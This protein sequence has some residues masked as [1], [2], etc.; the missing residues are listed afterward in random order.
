[1]SALVGTPAPLKRQQHSEEQPSLGDDS[2]LEGSSSMMVLVRKNSRP[3]LKPTSLPQE[4][5]EDEDEQHQ[6]DDS[7]SISPAK[8]ADPATFVK[9]L[10]RRSSV[11]AF[12]LTEELVDEPRACPHCRT[13]VNSKLA[14]KVHISICSAEQ[15][16]ASLTQ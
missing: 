16:T 14:L 12:V 11:A 1:M 3:S 4:E 2:A 6:Q 5:L 7:S 15:T 9:P 10:T 13:V 8:E